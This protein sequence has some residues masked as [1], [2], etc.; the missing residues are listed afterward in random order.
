MAEIIKDVSHEFERGVMVRL[1][2]NW[3]LEWMPF[4]ELRVQT[5]ARLGYTMGDSEAKFHLN[6]LSQAGYT[7]SKTLRAG[8]VD[9]EL[10]VV[11][12][13][14]KAVDLVEGRTADPGVAF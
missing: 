14:A 5:M 1:L 10:S 3:G 12:A 11:R 2:V 4:Q 7:E 9:F 13:T 8:R 6:Y